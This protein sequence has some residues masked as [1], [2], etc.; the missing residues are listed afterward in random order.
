MTSRTRKLV[1]PRRRLLTAKRRG[2]MLV[3]IVLLMLAFIVTLAFSVDIAYMQLARTELRTASDAAARAG[4]EALSRQLTVA[5]ARQAA[6]DA[7][8]RNFVAGE[9]LLLHDDDIVFGSSKM[10]LDGT[11]LFT[12]DDTPVNAVQVSGRRTEASLSGSVQ[13]FFGAMLG[14]GTFEPEQQAVA[15]QVDRDICLVVDRS[16]SMAWDLSGV[17]WSYPPGG[18][19]CTPPHASL[20]RWAAADTA[21]GAFLAEMPKTVQDEQLSL[22]TYASAGTWCADSYNAADIESELTNNYNLIVAAMHNR[23]QNAIPGSTSISAGMDQ[24]ILTLTNPATARPHALKTMIVLT[25][26][27]HN[28]GPAPINSASDA[29]DE[30]ITVHTITFSDGADQLQMQAVAAATGGNHYHAP[31]AESLVSIFREIA[32]TL[33]VVLTE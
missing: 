13:L 15:S 17:E 21:V 18:T 7:A 29:A 9:A 30:G 11:W 28:T 14:R 20:S 19:Y 25:D 5:Q 31:D 1:R 2:A 26:G 16:G 8:A 3:T 6:K 23:G 33:P 24:G 12:P 4:A 32:A 27:V 10:Q 22:V